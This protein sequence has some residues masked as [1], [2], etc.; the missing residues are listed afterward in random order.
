MQRIDVLRFRQENLADFIL[1]ENIVA[2]PRIGLHQIEPQIRI[3]IFGG[4]LRE[5]RL[6]FAKTSLPQE[7]DSFEYLLRA[8][9][10]R[11]WTLMVDRLQADFGCGD[12]IACLWIRASL[13]GEVLQ[14]SD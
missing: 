3:G 4:G 9:R 8:R 12:Q 6:R 7:F 13:Y 2:G 11:S 1:R 10:P 14:D 5:R